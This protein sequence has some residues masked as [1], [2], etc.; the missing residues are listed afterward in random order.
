MQGNFLVLCPEHSG[1]KFPDEGLKGFKSC[2]SNNLE[3]AMV[4]SE[5]NDTCFPNDYNPDSY[6][7]NAKTV[8][9]NQI[10]LSSDVYV[11]TME[12]S[13]PNEHQ[14]LQCEYMPKVYVPTMETSTLNKK[15]IHCEI[16]PE[17]YVPNTEAAALCSVK[18]EATMEEHAM[19]WP[20][21]K[22][23]LCASGLNAK[24]NVQSSTLLN[25]YL[26]KC[27]LFHFTL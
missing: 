20:T 24:T 10:S 4:E 11:P 25:I 1:S 26:N 19:K 12:A 27:D 21:S 9:H 14:S 18:I 17:V 2:F 7:S 15:I 22:W 16:Q 8:T 6:A 3:S 23:V 13:T 5:R